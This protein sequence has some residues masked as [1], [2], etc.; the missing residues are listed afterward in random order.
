[1]RKRRPSAWQQRTVI[2]R[3]GARSNL[4]LKARAMSKA[5]VVIENITP[6]VDCGQFPAKRVVGEAVIVEADVFTVGHDVVSCVLL[7][8]SESATTWEQLPMSPLH[9]DRWIARFTPRAMGRYLYTVRAWVDHLATWKRDLVKKQTAGQDVSVDILRGKQLEAEGL[10]EEIVV[11]H[12]PPLT[13]EVDR[14]R[15]QFSTWYELFPRSTSATGGKH[16]TFK[17]V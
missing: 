10:D 2:T 17:D 6:Q 14:A 12:E 1:V 15:A 11:Q 13:H 9:N 16:G 3:R 8:R 5:R 4:G 7:Y